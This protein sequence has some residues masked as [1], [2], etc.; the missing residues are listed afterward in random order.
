MVKKR[1]SPTQY[2]LDNPKFVMHPQQQYVAFASLFSCFFSRLSLLL[3][4]LPNVSSFSNFFSLLCNSNCL[5]E[6][7]F[8]FKDTQIQIVKVL[9]P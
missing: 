8:Q 1:T 6:W 2:V 5:K 9:D 3:L 4:H 7:C